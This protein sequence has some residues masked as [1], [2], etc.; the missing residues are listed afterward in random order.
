M[1]FI[2]K[3]IEK[4]GDVEMDRTKIKEEMAKYKDLVYTDLFFNR[5]YRIIGNPTLNEEDLVSVIVAIC[6]N[7]TENNKI[8]G[9]YIERFGFIE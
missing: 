2:L 3:F 9:K 5:L 4:G 8:L 7:R 1:C 6:E